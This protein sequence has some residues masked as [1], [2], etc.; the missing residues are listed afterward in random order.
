MRGLPLLLAAAPILLAGCKTAT[1]SAAPQGPA[2]R[3]VAYINV[4]SGCQQDTVSLLQKLTD[5]SQGKL[6]LDLVDFGDGGPGAQR[7][8][9]SGYNCMT[10][11]LNGSPHAKYTTASG[12]KTVSLQMP[13]G[14]VWTHEELQE[15]VQAGL[16]G[17]L[18]AVSEE[19]AEAAQPARLVKSLVTTKQGTTDGKPAA[20][21]QMDGSTV[22]TLRAKVRGKGPADR[23][24]AAG[25]ALR[26]WLAAPLKSSELTTRQV[27]DG[28]A[29]M[30]KDRAVVVATK[31]DAGAV[32]ASPEDI[33]ATWAV[34]VRRQLMAAAR[35]TAQE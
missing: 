19:E 10:I 11:E 20:Q 28:W 29:L 12:P 8:Q 30:A 34:A 3:I 22:M 35:S 18:A 25:A 23:A 13:A 27:T 15:A 5:D 4:S 1:K 14:L 21:V 24:K 6:Q 7:W 2:L 32:E 17:K 26:T 9:A 31:G 16:E 33:A